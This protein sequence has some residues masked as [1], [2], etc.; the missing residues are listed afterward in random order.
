M[1]EHLR[2][3]GYLFAYAVATIPLWHYVRDGRV[4]ALMIVVIT[5]AYIGVILTSVQEAQP[6]LSSEKAKISLPRWLPDRPKYHK[7][8][9]LVRRT[10]KWHLLLVP[11]K[12]GLALGFVEFF[13]SHWMNEI[14]YARITA[15]NALRNF[16][17]SPYIYFSHH[18]YS[19]E[20][21][22]PQI[23]TF[24]LGL[25]II[26]IFSVAKAGFVSA[27]IHLNFNTNSFSIKKYI[28]AI[29]NFIMI[30]FTIF[31][32]LIFTTVSYGIDPPRN[33]RCRSTVECGSPEYQQLEQAYEEQIRLRRR[34]GETIHAG[35]M[36]LT[37]DGVLLSANI[38]RPVGEN[39]RFTR[40]YTYDAEL[41]T[42]WSSEPD[43]RPFVARQVVAGLLGLMFYAGATWVILWFV[44]DE[45]ALS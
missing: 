14:E 3:I 30:A 16:F 19:F 20:H 24:F 5:L 6:I 8:W 22:Y 25:L 28:R 44:E 40:I 33:F 32:I 42:G 37:G 7:W 12:M 11:P 34:V 9:M 23:A 18:V 41:M 31:G 1:I 45:G 26:I 27:L 39:S 29:I 17:L 36:T 35:I 21:A 10:L 43:N 38:M 13:H 15:P 2:K 4:L